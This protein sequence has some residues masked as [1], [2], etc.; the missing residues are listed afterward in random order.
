M[1][2]NAATWLVATIAWLLVG[3]TG[4]AIGAELD[5]AATER[6][7]ARLGDMRGAIKP[8]TDRFG[9]HDRTATHSVPTDTSAR[10]ALL[11]ELEPMAPFS[12]PLFLLIGEPVARPMPDRPVRIVYQG[13]VL[14]DNGERW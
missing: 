5:G 3:M 13:T 11:P 14:A 4:A 8:V 2:R 9:D 10:T 7:V 12:G 1:A 6:L